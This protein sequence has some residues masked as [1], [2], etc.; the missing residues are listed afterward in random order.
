[1]R[2]N[3][4]CAL[5]LAV[6]AN[7]ATAQSAQ[8]PAQRTEGPAP[9]AQQGVQVWLITVGQGEQVWEKFGHNAL[10]FVDPVSGLDLAYN[11]G[12]FDFAQPG[13][14]RR[15]LTGDTRYWV[16][17]YPA[18]AL[19]DFYKR[20]DRSV[21]LQRLALT[22]DQTTRA[23]EYARWNAQEANKYYR[24]DYFR[25]NCSTR[26]RDVIDLALNGA[27]KTATSGTRT[28]RTYR[29]ESLRLVDDMAL[30]QFGINVALGHPADEP[31]SVWETM[32]IP[33]RMRDALR[34]MRIGGVTSVAGAPASLVAEERVLYES[35]QFHER[36]EPPT[37]WLPYLVVGLLIAGGLVAGSR[38]GERSRVADNAFRIEV[39]VWSFVTGLLGLVLLLAWTSTRHVFWF[40]NE[41]LLLVSPLALWLV[42]LSLFS[43][44]FER[45]ARPAAIISVII[46][47]LGA[48]ALILKG[49]PGFPQDNLALILLV[50]APQFVVAHGLRRRALR[51]RFIEIPSI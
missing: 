39:A 47:M 49:V 27:L 1:V 8:R 18:Q 36:E 40:R 31:L 41:N 12:I 42:P 30:T 28:D 23:L 46:A 24:Y 50:I 3:T 32:F 19:I 7:I 20:S 17:S 38:A 9:A 37:L 21:V 26:V 4:L 22:P 45:W 34:E 5:C 16:E 48:V 10:W 11:W 15:F 6:C 35:T 29:S 44:K 43:I 25:D 13:F 14:L 51:E 2:R 33:M